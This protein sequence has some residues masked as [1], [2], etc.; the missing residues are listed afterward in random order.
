MNGFFRNLAALN[1]FFDFQNFLFRSDISAGFR[2][3]E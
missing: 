1:E 2:I 3:A